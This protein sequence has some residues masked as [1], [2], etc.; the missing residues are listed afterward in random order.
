[1]RKHRELKVL[2]RMSL[3]SRIPRSHISFFFGGAP[4]RQLAGV[5]TPAV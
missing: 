4:A 5:A 3:A 2:D 1:V